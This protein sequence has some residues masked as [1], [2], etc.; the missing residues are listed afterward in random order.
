MARTRHL[1]QVQWSDRVLG[2][3]IDRLRELGRW[4]DS[5]V[6]V[7]SDHGAGIQPGDSQRLLT[8]SN[9]TEIAWTPLLVKLPGQTTGAVDDRNALS[10]DVLPTIAEVVGI[11]I[12]WDVVGQ[13]LLGEPRA[14]ATKLIREPEFGEHPDAR[15]GFVEL[16]P[17]GFFDVIARPGLPGDPGDELRPWRY[18]RHGELFGRSVDDI[19]T[20]GSG[21]S[22]DY[23]P[24]ADWDEFVRG[25]PGA[26]RLVPLWHEGRVDGDD[27]D[28]AL[29]VDGVVAGWARTNRGHFD[30]LVAEPAI[31]SGPGEVALY[32]ITS[33]ECL[34]PL[35]GG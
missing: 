28:V 35:G 23:E 10:V 26:V 14:D 6:I 22:A 7:T 33:G 19:G 11:E 32:E 2:A 21:P 18:G 30:I 5:L 15:D 20:C 34:S 4:D 25:G 12:G 8:R 16:D 17:A 13:S 31:G 9:E 24:P 27:I 3:T 1:L 29:A